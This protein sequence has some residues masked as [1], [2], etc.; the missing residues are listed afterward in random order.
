MIVAELFALLAAATHAPAEA[1]TPAAS[2]MAAQRRL[3]AV[4]V[5]EN[6]PVLEDLKQPAI[7]TKEG[8]DRAIT[9]PSSPGSIA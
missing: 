7:F 1:A 6:T 4:A 5:I 3:D 8:R 2:S 9:T